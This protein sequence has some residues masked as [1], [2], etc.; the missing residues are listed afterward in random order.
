MG[1]VAEAG[2]TAS[3]PRFQR[4]DKNMRTCDPFRNPILAVTCYH[5]GGGGGAPKAPKPQKQAPVEMPQVQQQAIQIPEAPP[6]PPPPPPIPPA[7]TV[8]NLDAQQA[9]ADQKGQAARRKGQRSTLIAGET[10]GALAPASG[11]RKTLL[12]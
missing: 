6:P 12:G 10:G 4:S 1:G 2:E 5:F 3:V 8:S 7:P 11:Q 9:A